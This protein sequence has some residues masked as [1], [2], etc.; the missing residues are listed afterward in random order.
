MSGGLFGSTLLDVVIGLFFI[1]LLLSLVCSA[2]NEFVARVLKLRAGTLDQGLGQLLG[3][4]L[5]SEVVNHGLIA[6]IS[7]NSRKNGKKAPSYIPTQLFS[8][9]LFDVLSRSAPNAGGTPPF[10]LEQLRQG[11]GAVAGRPV[12]E[13]EQPQKNPE[14]S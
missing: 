14:V 10:T 13:T 3:K 9:A 5:S 11:A 4:S 2:I 6:G 12:C 1:Y 8:Q 7:N